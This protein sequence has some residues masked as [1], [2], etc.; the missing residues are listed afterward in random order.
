M[1]TARILRMQPLR[2]A[3]L[4]QPMVRQSFLRQ[5]RPFHNSKM[6][7]RAKVR[8]SRAC[9]K[10]LLTHSCRRRNTAVSSR[11]SSAPNP[12]LTMVRC[13]THNHTEN[14]NTEEDPSRVVAVG[15]CHCVCW[16][17]SLLAGPGLHLA[18][19]P[20]SQQLSLWARSSSQTRHSAS[21]GP[22][23]RATHPPAPLHKQVLRS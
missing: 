7:L 15:C 2:Q 8:G 5:A 18:V 14:Q 10:P 20:C 21:A 16:S 22:P 6:M 1:N 23:N 3:A 9:E 12:S 4:Q 11:I 19:S 17:K 13:S